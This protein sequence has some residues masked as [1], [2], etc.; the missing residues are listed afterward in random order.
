MKTKQIVLLLSFTMSFCSC[1]EY[2][3]QRSLDKGRAV[4]GEKQLDAQAPMGSVYFEKTACFGPCTAFQFTW[5]EGSDLALTITRP[6]NEGPLSSLSPGHFTGTMTPGKARKHMQSI[7]EAAAS[8]QYKSLDD[9]YDNPRVTDLP[10]TITE[11]NGKRVKARYGAPD[12][13]S[14]YNA[15]QIILDETSWAPTE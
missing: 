14:L 7:N 12:L 5:N 15:L 8:C 1:I 9:A 3:M 2:R 10:S 4:N 13:K 6:F 11:I